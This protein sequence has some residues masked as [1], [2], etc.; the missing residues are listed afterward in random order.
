MGKILFLI[1]EYVICEISRK[2]HLLSVLAHTSKRKE[3]LEHLRLI[4][5]IDYFQ[6]T[7]IYRQVL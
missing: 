3:K 6:L 4:N 5:I 2:S 1:F 7:L